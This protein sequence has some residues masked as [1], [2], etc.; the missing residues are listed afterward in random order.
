MKV[1]YIVDNPAV[2]QILVDP[3]RRAILELLR[4]KPMTQSKLASELGLSAPSLNHHIK[5]LRSKRLVVIV[6]RE[7]ET[8]KVIQ[9]F[10]SPAAYLF[11]Y[12]LDA[13]PMNIARYFYPV[14]LERARGI[15]SAIRFKDAHYKMPSTFEEA[16]ILSE[17]ISRSLVH[18][19]KEYPKQDLES[20]LEEAVYKIYTNA[21]K[22]ALI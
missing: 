14:S 20:G 21:I 15:V 18:A 19:A 2:A 4:T 17:K 16:S 11:V 12:D 3:M 7:M 22:M 10:F 1:V 5:V 9:K 8:H 6:K 13:L